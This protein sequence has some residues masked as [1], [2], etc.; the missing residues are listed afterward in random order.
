MIHRK[1]ALAWLLAW[2]GHEAIKVISGVRRCGKSTLM[3]QY[4]QSLASSGVN[5]EQIL[6]INFE[7]MASLPLRQPE[8]LNRHVLKAMEGQT[9]P[10]HLL[11]DEVQLVDH[12][13]EVVNSLRLDRRFDLVITGSSAHLL[14]SE[15]ATRLSGRYVQQ[16]LLP[17][18]LKEAREQ[19]PGLSLQ[20]YLRFGGFPAVTQL[21]SERQRMTLLTDLT[22]SIL[23]KDILLRGDIAN[24]LVLR[25]LTSFL[26]DIVGQ[27]S[28]V[29]SI[30]RSLN[31]HSGETTR[32]ETIAKY[33]A[34]LKEAY[35]FFEVQR[36]D[37]R[38]KA[39][40]GRE[41]K[42]YAVDPGIRT[43]LVAPDSRNLG[44]VLENLVY[45][46]LLRQNYLVYVGQ[47]GERE[48]DFMVEKEGQRA[49]IQVV[50]SAMAE[51]TARREFAAFDQVQDH[52]PKYLLT[53]DTL[54]LSR[55]GVRHLQAENFLMEEVPD[56]L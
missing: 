13:E 7:N 4:A 53:L 47:A 24:P 56:L 18:S 36:Y 42:Y 48:I 1:E 12:W 26:L 14:A 2:Q 19:A 28:S 52:Y 22:D 25:N 41:P 3:T 23:F 29:R 8:A 49:Y 45:L 31:S 35:L 54:D 21:D 11:L 6:H 43:A 10:C 16:M 40:L 55:A 46:Q 32:Q 30:T 38:G 39:I 50:L 15:L 51:D 27:R 34:A 37:L 33:I 5:K 9:G 17:F 20:D 44:A